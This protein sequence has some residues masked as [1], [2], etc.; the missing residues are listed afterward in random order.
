[1]NLRK[2]LVVFAL[3]PLFAMQQ[4]VVTKPAHLDQI[5]AQTATPEW[6]RYR[7]E[8]EEF[9]VLLPVAPAM[10]TISTSYARDKTRRERTL[11]AYADGVV[12][13]IHTGEQK[14]ISLDQFASRQFVGRHIS[15]GTTERAEIDGMTGKSSIGETDTTI[16]HAKWV[17]TSKNL[18]MFVAVASKHVNSS[19]AISKFFSSISFR[20]NPEGRSVIDGSGEQPTVHTQSA[21]ADSIFRSSQVTFRATVVSKPE[22]SY[23]E[24]ARKS[25]V[26]GSIVLRVV[27]S[28]SGGVENITVFRGL[29]DGLTEKAIAAAQQIRFIPGIKD[30][31]FVSM[32][33]QLEYNFNLY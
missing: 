27:F 7:V 26:T 23:T 33:I 1:M 17:A 6:Q 24:Q 8:G 10:N 32:W 21:T 12:Y 4:A 9:S 15:S 22:P 25:Q 31:R 30:G 19:T 14:G 29:P 18:Y 20:K 3:V 16:R 5:G 2:L 13:L 28:S 11:G